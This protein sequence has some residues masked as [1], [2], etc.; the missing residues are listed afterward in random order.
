MLSSELRIPVPGVPDAELAVSVHAPDDPDP[1][2]PL[3]VAFPGGGYARGYYNLQ[4]PDHE[5]YSQAEHHAR[6]GHVVV[7]IDHLGVGDSSPADLTSLTLESLAAANA[8]VTAEVVSRLRAR[9]LSP[10]LPALDPVSVIGI[11][12]SLGGAILTVHQANY[13]TFDA[14]GILGWS[15]RQTVLPT[16]P[17]KDAAEYVAPARGSAVDRAFVTDAAKSAKWGDFA[18]TFHYDDVPDD[19]VAADIGPDAP[20]RAMPIP[21]WASATT[22]TCA[23]TTLSAGVVAVEADSIAAPVFIGS[24]ERDVVPDPWAEPDAYRSSTDITVA[25]FPRMA[26]MHNF[27]STRARL[28]DRLAAWYSASAH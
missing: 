24:G 20:I 11:G 17:D 21:P 28:W 14:V 27:A 13:R 18:Y 7:A 23:V 1:R 10:A 12:Q 4:L 6:A 9:T 25:V 5:G 22:P 26:H 8:G 15:A 2:A 3:V 16:P 19:I